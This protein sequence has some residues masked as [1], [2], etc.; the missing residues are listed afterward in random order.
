MPKKKPGLR[1][2]AQ[3]K[4]L[5]KENPKVLAQ[6]QAEPQSLGKLPK[7][8]RKSPKARPLSGAKRKKVSHLDRNKRSKMSG[9]NN[10]PLV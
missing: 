10:S 6:L 8:A 9:K 5:E 4:F 7:R 1:S 2:E 3:R